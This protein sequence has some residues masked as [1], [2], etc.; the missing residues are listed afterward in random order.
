[1]TQ[2]IS[3]SSSS[4]ATEFAELVIRNEASQAESAHQEREAARASVRE[5]A[6]KQID[7]L[8]DAA[9]ATRSGALLNAA[10]TIGGSALEIRAAFSQYG[11][12]M[13]CAQMKSAECR[14]DA[15]TVL[16]AGT[17][18]ASQ[19]RLATIWHASG[20]GMV[21]L[22][23]P[24]QALFGDSVAS[25]YQAEAKRRETL[26]EQAK[27]QADDASTAIDKSEKRG[28]KA[29]DTLQSIQQNENSSAVALIG[30]I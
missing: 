12:D 8:H 24:L 17:E 10:L 14:G 26:A 3:S 22:A 27:W 7:A 15:A 6:Q 25:D 2:A 20:D 23:A 4:F 16:S 29:L 18:F 5:N 30:R 13:A 19:N 21:K 11:A 28:D 1:M 9:D